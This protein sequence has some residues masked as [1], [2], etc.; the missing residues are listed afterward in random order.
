MT[1]RTGIRYPALQ[2]MVSRTTV[3]STTV[4][5]ISG[6]DN[7]SI[8]L[9]YVNLTISFMGPNGTVAL[10][11][12]LGGTRI[13]EWKVAGTY[14]LDWGPR[15]LKLALDTLLSLVVEGANSRVFCSAIGYIAP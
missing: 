12:G 4:L 5:L 7:E 11:E 14:T 9:T 3:G 8:Y 6:V 2:G 15:G 13:H 1:E 10:E